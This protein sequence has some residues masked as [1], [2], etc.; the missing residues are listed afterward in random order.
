M[1]TGAWSA[2][3]RPLATYRCAVPLRRVIIVVASGGGRMAPTTKRSDARALT[4]MLGDRL[5]LRNCLQEWQALAGRP[6]CGG[7]DT[8]RQ[9]LLIAPVQ[10]L[11]L[12]HWRRGSGEWPCSGGEIEGCVN[13][14]NDLS[15]LNNLS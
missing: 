15:G 12:S 10:D 6:P 1:I 11:E 8:R 7:R 4:G 5:P 13:G 9:G 2:P 3:I 14:L